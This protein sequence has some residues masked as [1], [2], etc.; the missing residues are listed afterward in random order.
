[1][2]KIGF[3]LCFL[4]VVSCKSKSKTAEDVNSFNY[5]SFSEKFSKP[6]LP[7]QLTDVQLLSNKDTATLRNKVF[8]SFIPD[9]VKKKIF[10]AAAKIRYTPVARFSEADAESYFVVKAMSGAKKIALLYVFDK[11]NE[12]G[13]VFPFLVPDDD[14]STSQVS[15]ID[16]SFSI[17]R[18]VSR[19]MKNDVNAEG[20]EVFIY[21]EE[22]RNFTLI[23]T[24]VLD[25]SSLAI[26]NPIDT[27]PRK[28]KYA[29]DYVNGK[30]N[31]VSIRD[32]KNPK[33]FSFFIH[34]EKEEDCTG[35]LKGTALMTSGKTAVYRQG[36]DP[37]VLEFSFG[38]KTVSLR[39]MEGCGSHRGVQCVFDGSFTKKADRIKTKK[40]RKK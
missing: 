15:S 25:K 9:S 37:C 3:A 35:D 31:I 38:S 6:A 24:D 32:A 8:S 11:K 13:A 19:K 34:F 28:S 21:N 1:M 23:M 27:F 39:E 2:Y 7:Y 22:A 26:I 5:E 18:A 29:G 20:K 30:R 10:G 33:E 40:T 14:P 16:K 4:V 17:T 12:I 36:G